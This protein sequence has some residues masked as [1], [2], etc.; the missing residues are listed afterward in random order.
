MDVVQRST[1][2][3][4]RS[5]PSVVHIIDELQRSLK[6]NLRGVRLAVTVERLSAVVVSF[7]VL[8]IHPRCHVP[9]VPFRPTTPMLNVQDGWDTASYPKFGF[10]GINEAVMAAD[11]SVF[12]AGIGWED[13]SPTSSIV[14]HLNSSGSVTWKWTVS[15]ESVG[16]R[17][18]EYGRTAETEDVS[19]CSGMRHRQDCLVLCATGCAHTFMVVRSGIPETTCQDS[20]YCCST[21]STRPISWSLV[22]DGCIPRRAVLDEVSSAACVRAL[23]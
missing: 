19:A 15:R 23:L 13:S 2:I 7:F 10:S 17:T 14:V 5:P 8:S 12:L 6:V 1:Y 20:R 11:G 21:P 16:T 3:A 4:S 18:V 22:V 9:T